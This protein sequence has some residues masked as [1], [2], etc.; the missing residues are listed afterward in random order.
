MDV[1]YRIDL[2]VEDQLIIEV[3]AGLP[4]QFQCCL[5]EARNSKSDS[6]LLEPQR[7]PRF[8]KDHKEIIVTFVHPLRSLW[9]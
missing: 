8:H 6:R 3:K 1:G 2:L 4:S 9:L 7:A 5:D